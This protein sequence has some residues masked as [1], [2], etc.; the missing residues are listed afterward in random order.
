[1]ILKFPDLATLQLA[2][3][4]STV[5]PAV[6]QTSA[7]ASF[8]GEQVWVETNAT[9]G[10]A[11]QNALKKMGAQVCR[12]AGGGPAREV[13]SWL[14]LLPLRAEPDVLAGLE[15][16]PVLFDMPDGEQ[17]A[18]LAGEMLRLGNDRQG[19]RWLEE[20]QRGT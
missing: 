3:T 10:R 16:T 1:M 15:Q 13:S 17:M 7:V 19:F 6:S 9:L 2:L 4:S 5:P 12:S 20:P 11:T 18:R 8:D 14:E